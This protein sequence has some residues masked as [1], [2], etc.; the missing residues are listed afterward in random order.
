MALGDAVVK[1]VEKG[2]E[3]SAGT[4]V[5]SM[6]DR[7]LLLRISGILECCLDWGE[8]DCGLNMNSP[9]SSEL[10]PKCI[11]GGGGVILLLFVAAALLLVV[12]KLARN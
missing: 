7:R 8:G 10:S 4:D 12:G 11:G 6:E 1:E 5:L 9:S 3:S 2:E